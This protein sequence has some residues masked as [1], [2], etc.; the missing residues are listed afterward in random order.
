ME[1]LDSD[2]SVPLDTW[3]DVAGRY[4]KEEVLAFSPDDDGIHRDRSGTTIDD[5]DGVLS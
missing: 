2:K 3:N 5:A 1:K 4:D